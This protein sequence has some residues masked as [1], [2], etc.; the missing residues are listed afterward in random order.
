MHE[1]GNRYQ[2]VNI[3]YAKDLAFVDSR[4]NMPV[5]VFCKFHPRNIEF[6]FE[7]VTLDHM[8]KL[9][10]EG[11]KGHM[12]FI[13]K[14]VT[15]DERDPFYELVGLVTL[16]D[17]IE[18]MIKA[19]IVDETDMWCK[20]IILTTQIFCQFNSDFNLCSGTLNRKIN[21]NFIF[22]GFL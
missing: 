13:L 10:R 4:L 1:T 9:F 6:V 11:S 16:E 19:E 7:D 2:V 21:A 18:E 20:L 5:S 17:I 12:A 15:H 22:L 14:V 8:L 3:L